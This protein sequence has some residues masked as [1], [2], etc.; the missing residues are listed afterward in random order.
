MTAKL[1][2]NDLKRD[3]KQLESNEMTIN[4]QRNK[5]TARPNEWTNDNDK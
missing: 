5:Q 3:K 2:A 1:F 4:P